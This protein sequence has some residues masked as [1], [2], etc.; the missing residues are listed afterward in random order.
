MLFDLRGRRKRVVQ[1]VYAMLAVMMGA[2][3]F[4]V[5]G[6]VNLGDLVNGGGS[7]SDAA[8]ISMDRA[9]Q[10]DKKLRQ[11][12]QDQNLLLALTRERITA[13]NNLAQIDPKTQAAIPTAESAQQYQLAADAWERYLKTSPSPPNPN[14]ALLVA[15]S[16]LSLAQTSTTAEE[17]KANAA[18]A[19]DAQLIYAHAKPSSGA[20]STLAYYYYAALDFKDADAAAKQAEAESKTKAERKQ[21]QATLASIRKQAKKFAQQLAAAQKAQQAQPGQGKQQLENPLGGLGGSG[22]G[23]PAP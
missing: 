4:L 14:V 9:A 18:A 16:L 10:L 15:N 3:L 21:V 13:G 2:S 8:S 22:L 6:P 23:S 5:V 19:G 11:N 17:A 12:P 20:F 1:V 7:S